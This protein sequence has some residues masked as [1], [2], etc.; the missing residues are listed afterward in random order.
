M[1]DDALKT[2]TPLSKRRWSAGR[3]IA[4]VVLIAVGVFLGLAAEQW[5]D[6]A[7]RSERAAET[8][9]RIRAEMTANRDEVNKVIDY[10]SKTHQQLKNFLT[11]PV[12]KGDEMRFRLDGIQPAQ[13]EQTAWQLS[14]AT[15][16]LV[17]IDPDLSFALA[18]IYG[19]Q[20]RYQGLTEGIT[21]AMYLRPPGE[22]LTAF[23]HSLSLY[24]SDIV[25][26]EPA[27]A[28]LYDEML[29]QLDRVLGR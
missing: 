18:R 8:L 17:D 12:A 6:R 4:E 1:S 16:A 10:H 28:K 7:D 14:L 23:Y 19:V 21:D 24:Y 15:Q 13:F 2:P 26:L 3:S 11:M 27:L 5:R 29:P 22:N 20:A 9:R 25:L